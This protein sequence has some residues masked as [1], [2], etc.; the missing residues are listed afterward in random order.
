MAN[1]PSQ[2][3]TKYPF[4]ASDNLVITQAQ[5]TAGFLQAG[6]AGSL[7][8]GVAVASQIYIGNNVTFLE[9]NTLTVL[10]TLNI[11]IDPKLQDG[12]NL[13][14]RLVQG[15][16]AF[17]VTPGTGFEAAT[18]VSPTVIN[19]TDCIEATLSGGVFK[20]IGGWANVR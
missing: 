11:F 20:F 12:A 1:L 17:A 4:G 6:A 19:K 7:N 15:G 14:I 8:T 18:P 5:Y 2:T 9:I 13:T 10:F 3:T 16:T